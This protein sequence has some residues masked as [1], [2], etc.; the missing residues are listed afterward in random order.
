MCVCV[1]YRIRKILSEKEQ[2]KY[3]NNKY[4]MKTERYICGVG[5][6]SQGKQNTLEKENGGR[7]QIR[8]K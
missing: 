7:Q 2:G 3:N 6:N 1:D 5:G 4:N 8:A